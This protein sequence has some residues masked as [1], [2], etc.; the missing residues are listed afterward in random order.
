M[1]EQVRKVVQSF[2]KIE[3]FCEAIA[4]FWQIQ[5]DKYSSYSS[6][7]QADQVLMNAGLPD[8]KIAEDN[9]KWLTE[10]KSKLEKYHEKMSTVNAS[11]NFPTS[12]TPSQFPS[13]TLETLNM[14]IK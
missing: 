1:A 13:I 3:C 2:S 7:T 12:L 5:S 10:Q 8:E 9:I 14:T 4:A 6:R 11:Y